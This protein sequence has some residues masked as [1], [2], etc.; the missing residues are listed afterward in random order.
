MYKFNFYHSRPENFFANNDPRQ[1]KGLIGW[2][3]GDFGKD[4]REFWHIWTDKNEK[5]N[6][7]IFKQDFDKIMGTLRERLLTD[8]TYM[9]SVAFNHPEAKIES[10]VTDSYGMFAETDGY[11]YDIRLIRE[12]GNYDFYIFCYDKRMQEPQFLNAR[13]FR[14]ENGKLTDSVEEIAKKTLAEARNYYVAD[15]VYE[16]KGKLYIFRQNKENSLFEGMD[17]ERIFVVPERLGT[18]LPDVAS[19][20]MSFARIPAKQMLA[21]NWP[22]E[23]YNKWIKPDEEQ[24]QNLNM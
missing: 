7:P 23:K 8:R 21:G 24:G 11:E 5:L 16:Q 4:G 2:L 1:T 19:E 10:E 13:R 22:A 6:T 14:D 18:Y 3:R 17:G 9:R 15:E 20:G 12:N